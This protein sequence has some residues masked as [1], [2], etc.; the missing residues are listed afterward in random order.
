MLLFTY[1][2]VLLQTGDT[3]L[4][5]YKKTFGNPFLLAT[6]CIHFYNNFGLTLVVHSISY[7]T[8]LVAFIIELVVQVLLQFQVKTSKAD[9]RPGLLLEVCLACCVAVITTTRLVRKH[10]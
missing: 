8:S 10:N 6:V 5:H 9:Y 4:H 2:P 3:F 7:F 1:D